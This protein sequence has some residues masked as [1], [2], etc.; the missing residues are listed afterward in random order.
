MVGFQLDTETKRKHKRSSTR[1]LM[2]PRHWPL[3]LAPPSTSISGFSTRSANL[4]PYIFVM[5]PPPRGTPK[6]DLNG[7]DWFKPDQNGTNR[8]ALWGKL[9][10]LKKKCRFGT[11]RTWNKPGHNLITTIR[12]EQASGREQSWSSSWW[13]TLIIKIW[14]IGQHQWCWQIYLQFTQLKITN[15]C[16]TMALACP[17]IPN[18]S[19][20]F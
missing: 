14:T 1:R 10:N 5:P 15:N 6:G 13:Y 8:S 19:R 7:L 9:E 11:N 20:T 4:E 18:N 16:S 2:V 3:Y 17:T 12:C